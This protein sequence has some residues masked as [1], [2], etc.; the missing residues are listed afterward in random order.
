MIARVGSRGRASILL[1]ALLSGCTTIG[2]DNPWA[3]DDFDF[4]P[5]LTLP[6][7][8]IRDRNVSS[9][10]AHRLLADWN[11]RDGRLYGLAFEARSETVYPR[12]AWT[13]AGLL[14]DARRGAPEGCERVV[15]FVGWA[16]MDSIYGLISLGFG[17]FGVPSFY[18]LGVTSAERDTVA[19]LSHLGSADDLIYE[20]LAKLRRPREL[21]NP[22]LDTNRKDVTVHELY[23]VLGCGHALIKSAECYDAI[24]RFKIR[25]SLRDEAPPPRESELET[26]GEP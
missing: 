17:Y 13:T 21:L 18:V 12:T 25:A 14:E 10:H 24:R 20:L 8:M 3:R 7:C 5:E 22:R 16:P 1:L 6:L 2:L 19:V 4:G 9:G 11:R 26:G 15:Y 23:H